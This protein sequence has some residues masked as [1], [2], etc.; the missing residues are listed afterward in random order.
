[1]ETIEYSVP[2]I[3][4]AHCVATIRRVV[5]E[6]PGVQ[7]VDADVASKRVTVAFRPPASRESIAAVLTEWGF[8]PAR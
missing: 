4:C 8:P 1:M 7:S 2:G 6:I 5:G 3:S